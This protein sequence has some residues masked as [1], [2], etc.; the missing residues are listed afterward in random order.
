[1]KKGKKS[2]RSKLVT[3]LDTACSKY[4]RLRDGECVICGNVNDANNGHLFTRNAHST[5]WDITED[6]NCHQQC[7]P[8]NYAHEMDPYPYINWY[9]KKFGQEKYDALRFRFKTPRKFSEA[10]LE[11]MLE[12]IKEQTKLLTSE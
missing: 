4:I 11:E 6:G 2:E 10:E 3:K 8:C 1:M 9:I 7:W 5:R 12:H